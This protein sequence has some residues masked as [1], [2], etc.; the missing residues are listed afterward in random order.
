MYLERWKS[1]KNKSEKSADQ[2]NSHL[3]SFFSIGVT[4]K[5][6]LKEG[7]ERDQ[8][9][10]SANPDNELQPSTESCM[11]ETAMGAHLRISLLGS[12]DR[13]QADAREMMSPRAVSD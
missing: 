12:R 3:Q 5:Y 2:C 11:Q 4:M 1:N 10:S 7:C 8:C 6:S 13:D 9:S